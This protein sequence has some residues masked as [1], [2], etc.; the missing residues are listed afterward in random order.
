MHAKQPV[1][2]GRDEKAASEATALKK[3]RGLR[4]AT[5]SQ[6][7]K[8]SG[9][10]VST[11]SAVLNN[12]PHCWASEKSRQQV[13][14]AARTLG[15]RPNLAARSLRGGK[16]HVVGLI[17][18]ALNVDTTNEKIRAFEVA[19]RAG[20][21]VA[22]IAFNPNSSEVEDNLIQAF[23][24]RHIDGML[25]YPSETGEHHEM[26][27]LVKHGF[28]LVTVDGKGRLP[29]ETNDIS[30]DYFL[31]GRMQAE[32][33]IKL[34][35]RRLAQAMAFP[36]CFVTEQLRAG[37][38]A[39][40]VAA[41][42]AAP[43]HLNLSMRPDGGSEITPDIYRQV[44]AFLAK[45]RGEIDGF[46]SHDQ[47]AATAVHAS[48]AL[49]IRVPEELAIIGFDDTS[50]ASNCVI[51]LTTVA[52]KAHEVGTKSFELLNVRMHAA[53]GEALESISVDPEVVVRASSG[54]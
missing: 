18:A 39:A 15:Y 16:S 54:G 5:L 3:P 24:D 42:V 46:I 44:Y 8:L 48:L 12:Q 4:R 32:H 34:G 9:L 11:V 10:S 49:G 28:P 53:A 23:W 45:H 6:V 1:S 25:V 29:F 41:G 14:E 47:V 31:A 37:V 20:N 19:A 35:R 7:A 22:M 38:E 40:V 33:L 21:Y 52:Q 27:T 30:T 13:Y 2:K 43:V 50:T 51:P 17:T 26:R 36:S